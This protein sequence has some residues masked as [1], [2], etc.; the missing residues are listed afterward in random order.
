MKLQKQPA[1]AWAFFRPQPQHREKPWERSRRQPYRH[2]ITVHIR[3]VLRLLSI[4]SLKSLPS[5]CGLRTSRGTP[6]IILSVRYVQKKCF[7]QNRDLYMVFV[8]TQKRFDSVENSA[9]GNALKSK[10]S[11]QNVCIRFVINESTI[12][13]PFPITNDTKLSYVMGALMF[14]IVLFRFASCQLQGL[15]QRCKIHKAI[16]VQLTLFL[17]FVSNFLSYNFKHFCKNVFVLGQLFF[18]L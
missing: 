18:F 5:P 12:S 13:D 2:R 11:H 9:S 14:S 4:I 17:V 3:E 16:K 6:H 7:E 1:E 15:L 8:K 10:M